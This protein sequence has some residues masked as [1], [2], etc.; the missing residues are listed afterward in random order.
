MSSLLLGYTL[1]E[2][3][4]LVARQ[5]VDIHGLN[6]VHEFNGSLDGSRVQYAVI[7]RVAKNKA[8]SIGILLKDSVHDVFVEAS[9]S[10]S[11][12]ASDGNDFSIS[13]INS[14]L[15][16]GLRKVKKLKGDASSASGSLEWKTTSLTSGSDLDDSDPPIRADPIIQKT[17]Y[18]NK[19]NWNDELNSVS[20]SNREDEMNLSIQIGDHDS[21][22]GFVKVL[23]TSKASITYSFEIPGFS[24]SGA[25]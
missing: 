8:L 22:L 20:F 12:S 15:D 4:G 2:S 13:I 25:C 18:T 9:L 24:V 23:A 3:Q 5:I 17:G 6:M 19:G 14:V 7:A 16:G 11:S 10:S 1:S 21:R